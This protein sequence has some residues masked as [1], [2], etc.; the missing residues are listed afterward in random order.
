L[1]DLVSKDSID[2]VYK[3][4]KHTLNVCL[5]VLVRAIRMIQGKHVCVSK[6]FMIF[7]LYKGVMFFFGSGKPPAAESQMQGGYIYQI[8][9]YSRGLMKVTAS[10]EVHRMFLNP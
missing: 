3:K 10:F 9:S 2:I 7:K 5:R 4:A 8:L 6:P 1:A